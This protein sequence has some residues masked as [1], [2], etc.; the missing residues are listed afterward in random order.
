MV[1]KKITPLLLATS[2]LVCGFSG[3]FVNSN[4][5]YAITS[6]DELSDVDQSNWAY[7]AL[8]E[9]VEKYNVIEGYPDK[10]FRGDR[11]TTRYELAAALNA[12]IKAIGKEIARLGAEKAD[13]KD[14]AIVAKL[15]KEFA[16]ELTALQ[17]RTDA[18]E[19][20]ATKIEAKNDEQD[21]R[22]AIIEK[23]RMYGDASFGGYADIAG[24]QGSS[25]S[26][27]I[28][29]VGRT[30]IN[31][32]YDVIDDK[33]EGI[34]GPGTIH[35]R[36]VAAFGR[37]A[38]LNA[39]TGAIANNRYSGASS[40][41]SDSSFYNEGIR[42]NDKGIFEGSGSNVRANAYLDSA[43]YSQVLKAKLYAN[44]DWKT[45]F[46]FNMGLTPWRDIYFKS[47]YQ[48]NENC[49]FQNT[50]LINN[51]AILTNSTAPRIALEA[52]QGLGKYANFTLKGDVSTL[53]ISD[54]IDGLGFTVEGNLG[55]NLSFLDEMLGTPD[56][57]NLP[58]NVFGGF[59][60]VNAVGGS[61][62]LINVTTTAGTV[63]PTTAGPDDNAVGF[64]AGGNQEIYKGFGIFGSYAL[65]DTGPLSSLLSAL[66]NG[67][68]NSVIFNSAN[69]VFGVKQA[70]TIGGELPL[71]TLSLNLGQRS[72]DAIGV[73]YAQISP[74]MAVGSP[75]NNATVPAAGASEKVLE[76]YYR[77]QISDGF[78][79]IPSA[80][81]IFSRAGYAPNETNVVIGLRSSFRF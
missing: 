79:L 50:A 77:L 18:L 45:A 23:M 2:L 63:L 24:N 6:V 76:T 16:T 14:L 54:A 66:Q 72:N 67:T 38:P 39:N 49:Q 29:M 81:V 4:P 37:V 1:A 69:Q 27:A 48:G 41:A 19:A 71:K 30:R 34:V 59:Y 9:L 25:F 44:E 47:P 17:A 61:N 31:V 70:W 13:K 62:S 46:T 32:D 58:G 11:S 5:A 57:F 12:T 64:Y 74:N 78:A 52:K 36:L 55:Y 22:L 43:Y 68:G 26:D 3:A 56:M 80:Q 60:L 8:K 42:T 10:T 33:S 75:S 28:S 51:P 40:I 21:N 15:Q 20:R 65:N 35:S 53:D 7:N 73:A